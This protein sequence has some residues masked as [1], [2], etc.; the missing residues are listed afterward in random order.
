M[1]KP[2]RRSAADIAIA[3]EP[4]KLP[5]RHQP[6]ADLPKRAA[7][8][9]RQTVGSMRADWFSAESLPMLRAYCVHS[10]RAEELEARADE[11]RDCLPDYD[12][13]LKML[14]REHRAAL[15][16]ARSLRLTKQAQADPKRAGNQKQQAPHIDWTE[17]HRS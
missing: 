8:I 14:D 3:P 15:A 11:L 5:G 17:V 9:W 16:L 4:T 1:K 2:G 12:R 13:A 10:V 6:P 7:D